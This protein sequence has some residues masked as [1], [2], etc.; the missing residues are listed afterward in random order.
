MTSPIDAWNARFVI[1]EATLVDDDAQ[2]D[3]ICCEIDHRLLNGGGIKY[4]HCVF[5][6]P[7]L[8][9]LRH[10]YGHGKS[11]TLEIRADDSASRIWVKEPD[12]REWFE[13]LNH[14]PDTLD[15]TFHQVSLM[16]RIR[17]AESP[18]ARLMSRAEARRR[19]QEIVLQ[20]QS[21][22]NA[23]GLTRLLRILGLTDLDQRKQ[24]VDDHVPQPHRGP[25]NR[26]KARGKGKASNGVKERMFEAAPR[27]K[28]V[29]QTSSAS[30]P[31][32]SVVTKGCR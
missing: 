16:E 10:R 23:K 9:D 24:V 6:S 4:R 18:P 26:P 14:D 12:K 8:K 30:I 28:T 2:L 5:D 32:Y 11:L 27:R 29:T 20:A 22:G 31:I 25:S 1:E 19:M 21:V 7:T 15:L 3:V 13:V 17:R